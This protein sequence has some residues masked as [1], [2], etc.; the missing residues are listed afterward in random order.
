MAPT[1]WPWRAPQML[2]AVKASFAVCNNNDDMHWVWEILISF[3]PSPPS[4]RLG[5]ISAVVPSP[6]AKHCHTPLYRP[7]QHRYTFERPPRRPRVPFCF[8]HWCGRL[9]S[10]RWQPL[11]DISKHPVPRHS[12]VSLLLG[13]SASS[14]C[15]PKWWMESQRHRQETNGQVA[16]TSTPPLPIWLC[17]RFSRGLPCPF[18]LSSSPFAIDAAIVASTDLNWGWRREN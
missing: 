16:F 8:P 7:R 6:V 1:P 18:K 17:I 13:F 10:P 4:L 2:K 15:T 5:Y 9:A 12:L 11:W 14:W 3:R